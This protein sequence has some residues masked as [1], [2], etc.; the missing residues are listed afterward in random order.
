VITAGTAIS[1]SFTINTASVSAP[2]PVTI[3]A[4]YG[5]VNRPAVLTVNPPSLYAIGLASPSVSGGSV[6]AGNLVGLS[7]VAP[8]GGIVVQ[9]G[10]SNSGVA[11]TPA[12]VFVPAGSVYS[13]PFSVTTQHVGTSTPITITATWG[14]AMVSVQLTVTP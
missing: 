8:G 3:T 4:S 6:L 2:T 13:L 5:G 12:T 7:A 10:S 11:A 1:P 9:L 14:G